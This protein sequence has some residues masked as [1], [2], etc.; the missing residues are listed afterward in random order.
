VD[1]GRGVGVSVRRVGGERQ[2]AG[3]RVGSD[4]GGH[5]GHGGADLSRVR[6]RGAGVRGICL[7]KAITSA[8]H[9]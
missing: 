2:A 5:T 8:G 3:T 7:D 1:G 6:E 9:P 4:D